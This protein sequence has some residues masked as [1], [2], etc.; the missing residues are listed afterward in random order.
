MR[1]VLLNGVPA[2]VVAWCAV[3]VPVV[4]QV[5]S[6][7]G[8]GV[9]VLAVPPGATAS[10]AVAVNDAGVV[11]GSVRVDGRNRPVRWSADGVPTELALP[12]RVGVVVG[13]DAAGR[14]YGTAGPLAVRWGPDGSPT[15][16]DT[17]P[18]GRYGQVFAVNPAGVAVG[19]AS[20]AGGAYHAV[21]WDA[22]GRVTTLPGGVRAEAVDAGGAIAGVDAA[23]R[24]VRWDDGVPTG[25]VTVPGSTRTWVEA[26]RGPHAIAQ[27]ARED[28]TSYAVRWDGA[29]AVE[30]PATEQGVLRALG[31][32]GAAYGSWEGKAVRWDLDGALT[33]LDLPDDYGGGQVELV[34]DSGV[35]AGIARGGARHRPVRWS[36]TGEVELLPVPGAEVQGFVAGLN[37]AGVV[38]GEV[39]G[40]AVRWP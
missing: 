30:L 27:F 12:D 23:D 7:A 31:A 26:V 38:V 33:S 25:P 35:K 6:A 22:G 8:P 17:L 2:L 36:S 1:R 14:A 13:V 16:L 10:R 29:G 11:V 24:L 9:E 21:R 28:R 39:A 3:V 19:T 40:R 5:G 34:A 15:P 32:D 18:G 37:A 20:D 4:P